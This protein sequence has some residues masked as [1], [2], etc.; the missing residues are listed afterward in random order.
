MKTVLIIYI[1]SWLIL[2]VIFV[3]N[4][5][6]K[7]NKYESEK[8]EPWYFYLLIILLSPI[9]AIYVLYAFLANSINYKKTKLREKNAKILKSIEDN[10]KQELL[11]IKIQDEFWGIKFG[12]SLEY[13]KSKIDSTNINEFDKNYLELLPGFNSYVVNDSHQIIFQDT[14]WDFVIFDFHDNKFCSIRFVKDNYYHLTENIP[15]ENNKSFDLIFN[16]LAGIYHLITKRRIRDAWGSG[17]FKNFIK[18]S[19]N[20][21]D[22]SMCLHRGTALVNY[23]TSIIRLRFMDLSICGEE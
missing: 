18:V 16:R 12:D 19:I 22:R 1:V 7:K 20:Y 8:K 4:L 17:I 3:S 23:D 6:L 13:F 2:L 15:Y 11:C 10:N 21:E 9:W 14:K 5:L